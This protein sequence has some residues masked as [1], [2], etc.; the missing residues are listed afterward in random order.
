[1]IPTDAEE[2]TGDAAD[3]VPPLASVPHHNKEPPVAGVAVNAEV[4]SFRQ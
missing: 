2:G 3:D 1:M 4:I